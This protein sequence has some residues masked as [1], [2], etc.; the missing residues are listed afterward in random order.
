[1]TVPYRLVS[2]GEYERAFKFFKRN[3]E[4]ER[5][6]YC[7]ET[8]HAE[9]HF[10]CTED[11]YSGYCL[12]NGGCYLSGV[13]SL[14]KGNRLPSIVAHASTMAKTLGCDTLSLNC[15]QPIAHL[16]G[17]HGFSTAFQSPFHMF[18]KPKGWHDA[19]GEPD[20]CFMVKSLTQ[21]EHK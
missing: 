19:M 3:A 8:P 10:L 18:P 20:N 1:M 21:K 13:F 9:A 7:S 17:Q 4:L 6:L 2:K 5:H 12:E 14:V 11:P 15:Y 16:Y